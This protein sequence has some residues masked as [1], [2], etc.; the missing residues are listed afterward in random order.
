MR[1]LIVEDE[2]KTGA[3]LKKGLEESGFSV[4]LAKDGGEGLTLAQEESYDVIV[5]DV[6]LPV[7]DGW[8]VLKRLRDTQTAEAPGKHSMAAPMAVSSCHTGVLVSCWGST[9]L[10]LRMVGRGTKPPRESMS[11]LSMSRRTHRLFV[12]KNWC[13]VMS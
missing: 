1:I 12:L 13:L 6:M 8:S 10:P 2:P 9:V 7:L 11:F 3:Y 5:L 4:D